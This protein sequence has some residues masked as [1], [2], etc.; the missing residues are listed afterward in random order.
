M[1]NI[2]VLIV[3]DS[4][5]TQAQLT[6]IFESD[7][8]KVISKVSNGVSA[9]QEFLTHKE[10]IDLVTLD[11]NIPGKDGIEVLKDLIKIDP[12]VKVIMVSAMGKDSVI[13]ECLSLGAKNFIV[14][15][16]NKDKILALAKYVNK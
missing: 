11:I 6:D 7:G 9:V 14:K 13:K 15:P 2:N 4:P 10:K 12:N 5:L 1:S 16:F 8:H 3:D